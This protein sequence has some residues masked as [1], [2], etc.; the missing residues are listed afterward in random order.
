M[1]LTVTVKSI[2]NANKSKDVRGGMD[3]T[4]IVKLR[5]LRQGLIDPLL[6]GAIGKR[7][8]LTHEHLSPMEYHDGRNALYAVLRRDMRF[9]IDVDFHHKQF[10]LVLPGDLLDHRPHHPAWSTPFRPEID[11]NG[12]IRLF[13]Q[14]VERARECRWG[15]H[16]YR[17]LVAGEKCLVPKDAGV[18][19]ILTGSFVRGQ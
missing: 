12:A 10:A 9:L 3:L 17:E 4:V 13:D 18:D 16:D 5:S 1:D 2:E 6:Q 19:G 15:I 14:I 7:A 8:G 11:K